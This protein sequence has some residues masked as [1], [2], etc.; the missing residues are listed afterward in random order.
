MA[1]ELNAIMMH[2]W[3]NCPHNVVNATTMSNTPRREGRTTRRS[4]QV[5][6]VVLDVTSGCSVEAD[7]G[8]D[9]AGVGGGSA[10][11]GGGG[12]GGCE[13]TSG[14]GW[15]G[16]ERRRDPWRGRQTRAIVKL[17]EAVAALGP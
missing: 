4:R 9:A 6:K 17:R 14:A 8:G 1:K 2:T 10:G 11:G 16:D 15:G 7:S 5:E 3:N 12:G 13:H